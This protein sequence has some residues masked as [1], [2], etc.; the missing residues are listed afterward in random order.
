MPQKS[1]LEVLE[2]A[3]AKDPSNAFARYG[4]AMELARLGR[5]KEAQR[6]FCDLARDF[7]DY[8]PT[9]FQAARQFEK[10]GELDLARD[11]YRRGIDAAAR[12]GN[13]HAREELE[14]ALRML[15]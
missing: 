10:A 9:Y 11:F 2:E 7:P 4:L 6:A 1:R 13:Q 5:A 14:A 12:A 3:A 8:V 15:G